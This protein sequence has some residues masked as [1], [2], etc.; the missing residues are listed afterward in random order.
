MRAEI[1]F[2]RIEFLEHCSITGIMVSITTAKNTR[3]KETAFALDKCLFH[4]G[5]MTL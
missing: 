5:T 3:I 2:Q 4:T 1:P